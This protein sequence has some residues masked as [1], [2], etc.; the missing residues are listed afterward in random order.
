MQCACGRHQ[1][2]SRSRILRVKT[3]SRSNLGVRAHHSCRCAPNRGADARRAS[4][5]A[6]G[7]VQLRHDSRARLASN[8]APPRPLTNTPCT[9]GP[10]RAS[11]LPPPRPS[12]CSYVMGIQAGISSYHSCAV[13]TVVPFCYSVD[14][15]DAVLHG[16]VGLDNRVE[17]RFQLAAA[18]NK[19]SR[20]S[21]FCSAP[22]PWCPSAR[23]NISEPERCARAVSIVV[24]LRPS[25]DEPDA[26]LR[27]HARSAWTTERP[28]TCAGLALVIMMG[29]I[30]GKP[31]SGWFHPNGPRRPC[32][33][34][35]GKLDGSSV[36]VHAA[37]CDGSG[38]H[39]VSTYTAVVCG[40][41]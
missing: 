7:T 17:T 36:A 1:W 14:E 5:G 10:S 22:P 40:D 29:G 15:A 35:L 31:S 28:S 20:A 34:K 38:S 2:P 3:S 6:P 4:C 18:R 37:R 21:G 23:P 41:G 25:E 13:S 33:Q 11:V 32:Y 39:V 27:G 12:T 26:A 8:C 19:P 24:L 16:A 9:D 30:V